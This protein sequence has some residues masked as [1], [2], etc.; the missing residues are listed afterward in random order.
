MSD[1]K[2]AAERLAEAEKR[3]TDRK[4]AKE[5]ARALQRIEDLEACEQ[6]EEQLGADILTAKINV[7]HGPGLPTLVMVR[8]PTK[9]ELTRYRTGL[10]MRDGSP[11]PKAATEAAEL[12][13]AVCVVYPDRKGDVWKALCEAR[14]GVAA[15]AGSA[16]I[17]LSVASAESEGNG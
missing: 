12:L 3:A 7:E 16:A 6:I 13:A 4:A 17:K 15:G 2:T 5:E 9:P 10:K 14:P 11:D 8:C 1:E